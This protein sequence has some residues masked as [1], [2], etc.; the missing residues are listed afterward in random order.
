MTTR[1]RA[2][3][4]DIALQCTPLRL[5]TLRR[6]DPLLMRMIRD[7]GKPLMRDTGEQPIMQTVRRCMHP[8]NCL[9]DV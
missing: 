9:R 1:R 6:A 4:S 8:S 2:R 7:R 3:P 5:L